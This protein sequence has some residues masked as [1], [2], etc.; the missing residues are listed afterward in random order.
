VGEKYPSLYPLLPTGRGGVKN[1]GR[2]RDASFIH[3]FPID[4]RK[5]EEGPSGGK[6]PIHDPVINMLE[7]GGRKR[8][9][10]RGGGDRFCF[11][12]PHFSVDKSE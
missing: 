7:E 12:T 8:E 4:R 3:L 2:E 10:L 11:A 6:V 5:E 1:E 9:N